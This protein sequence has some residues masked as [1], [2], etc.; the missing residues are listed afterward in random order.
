MTL[1]QKETFVKTDR[2]LSNMK[3][4]RNRKKERWGILFRYRPY[5]EIKEDM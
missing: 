4:Q 5:R 1:K 2:K 3:T